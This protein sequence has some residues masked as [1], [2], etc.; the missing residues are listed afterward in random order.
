MPFLFVRNLQSFDNENIFVG[1]GGN[2]ISLDTKIEGMIQPN[3]NSSKFQLS[4]WNQQ[5][6]KMLHFDRIMSICVRAI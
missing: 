3:L 6:L 1:V 4:S 2:H 5:S